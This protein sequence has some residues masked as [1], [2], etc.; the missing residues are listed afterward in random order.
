M[1]KTGEWLI[2]PDDRERTTGEIATLAAGGKTLRF[3]NCLRRKGGSY[4]WLSW[5][6]VPDRGKIYAVARDMTELR[7]AQ[8]ELHRS[9]E[10]LT[11][12]NRQT[13]MAA[14]TASIAHEMMT[15]IGHRRKRKR[16]FALACA[17]ETRSRR[18][19]KDPEASG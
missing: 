13:T 15:I 6:A 1:G 5:T 10:E 16:W 14:M 17:S 7:Q 3:G 11:R 18:G 19:A 9:R 12:V 8:E 4:R 2:H